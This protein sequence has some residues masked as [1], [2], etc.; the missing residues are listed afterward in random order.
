MDK[1]TFFMQL[2]FL[3]SRGKTTIEKK[4]QIYLMES[5]G[6]DAHGDSHKIRIPQKIIPWF[7]ELYKNY[8]KG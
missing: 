6:K 8:K 4:G 2:A 3:V 5:E 1:D 7:D